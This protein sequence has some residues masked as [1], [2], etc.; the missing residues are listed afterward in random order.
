MEAIFY[1]SGLMILYAY[2]GY[3]LALLTLRLFIFRPVN[4]I[5]CEPAVTLIVPAYNEAG[6]IA[7]KINNA[8]RLDYPA[9]RLEVLIA[10][11]G[12]TDDTVRVAQESCDGQQ[13][14]V[15][16]FAQNRGKMA[17]LNDAVRAARGEI[18]L[19]SDAS[20]MLASDSLR[21]IVSNF[22]DSE[23]GAVSGMYRIVKSASGLLGKQEG[24]YWK[25]ET[26]L[27]SQES[28]LSSVLG[29]HGQILAVRKSLY[30]YPSPETINDDYVIPLR[31]MANGNR[32]VYEPRAIAFEEASKMV[33]FQRRV[34]IMAGN[35]QQ[36]KEIKG[37]LVP[38]RILPLFFFLSH[39][40]ARTAV[41]FFMLSL[42]V[43]NALLL[44]MHAYRLFG[45]SQLAFY[46]LALVGLQWDLRPHV[47][48]LPYYFCFVNVA[49]LWG[50]YRSMKGIGKVGWK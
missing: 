26:F 6:V 22:S 10:C 20:A 3:P 36:L 13:F 5:G 40:A 32:V 41:P 49:Y 7:A 39:K 34:R 30:P 8:A 23:V 19:L 27:K 2:V 9:D 33:G 48:R 31:I 1:V 17:V 12:S 29:G 44:P 46:A 14:R 47:L 37:L 50:A 24:F 43:S 15:L 35:L 11:D 42:I 45:L 28:A 38:P 18:V 16:P 4:K 21:E 25:Y